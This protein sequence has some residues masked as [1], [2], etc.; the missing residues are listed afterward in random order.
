MWRESAMMNEERLEDNREDKKKERLETI[1]TEDRKSYG[2]FIILLVIGGTIGF[3]AGFLMSYIEDLMTQEKLSFPELFTMVQN[4]LV[5]PFRYITMIVGA[6]F[7]GISE[8]FYRKARTIWKNSK[9]QD[10]DYDRTDDALNASMSFANVMTIA[11][12]ICFG[13]ASYHLPGNGEIVSFALSIA[14]FMLYVYGAFHMQHVV[15]NMTKEMNPEKKGSLYDKKF[16]KQWYES[17]DEA[18]RRQIGI[19][20]Y[21]T[22]QVTGVACMLFMIVFMMLGMVIEVGILPMLVPGIIWLVQ[23]I[24]YQISCKKAQ[25][26]MND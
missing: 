19:A 2:K 1:K 13:I 9:D 12:F 15:V 3:I 23:V 18:E 26:M 6:V 17:C 7:W 24:T 4:S 25:K 5:I 14:F 8:F 22:V 16:K 21:H 10:E 11:N 20:S